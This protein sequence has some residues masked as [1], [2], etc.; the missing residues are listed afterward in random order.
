MPDTLGAFL[1]YSRKD[2]RHD[3]EFITRFLRLVREEIKQQSRLEFYIFQ[4]KADINWGDEWASSIDNALAASTF[5]IPVITPRYLASSNCRDEFTTFHQLEQ[6]RGLNDRI[7][8]LYYL[9]ADEIHEKAQREQD[10]IA[11]ILATRQWFDIRDLRTEDESSSKV[12]RAVRDIADQ[13]VRRLRLGDRAS[14]TAVPV[15]PM[16]VRVVSR[17]PDLIPSQFRD[18]SEV[19]DELMGRLSRP[20]RRLI[21]LVG[22]DGIGKTALVSQVLK[23]LTDRDPPT[24]FDA[25][26]Y[27]S[28]R[29]Y[30]P[31][32]ASTIVQHLAVMH[33]DADTRSRLG[34]RL[35]SEHLTVL[36]K[37]DAVLASALHEGR[38]VVHDRE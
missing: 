26:G 24:R 33:P 12:R 21:E 38:P 10:Q 1:S 17:P 11:H 9:S 6:D 4:D 5:L 19:T 35:N 8:P 22:D 25:F 37:L 34:E 7:L 20:D 2:D 29:S 36:E 31:V 27:L 16:H 30:A 28:T 23:R 15:H 3:G 14:T 32:N 18:R 13:L